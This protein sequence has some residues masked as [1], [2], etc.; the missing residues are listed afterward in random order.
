M[1]DFDLPTPDLRDLLPKLT[2]AQRLELFAGLTR[3]QLHA[4]EYDWRLWARPAQLLPAGDWD[5]WLIL[6]GRGWGKTRTGAEAVR[7]WARTPGTRIALVGR[8][9]A[10]VRDVVVEGQTGVLAVHPPSERPLYEP[11]KRRLTW[12]NGAQATCYSADEPDLLRGPQH[13]KALCD[14]L[15]TW[16]RLEEAWDN[17]TLG[18]RLGDHPQRAIATT[19]RP[20][21]LL[22]K[23]L[24]DPRC[25]VTRGSTYENA[26]N[27]PTSALA[28]FRAKYEGTRLGRQELGAEILDDVPGAL[29]TRAMLDDARVKEAPELV[30]V[31]VAV[32]PAVSSGEDADETGIVVAGASEAGHFYVLA[33]RSCRASP[34][35]WARR[36]VA[37]YEEWRADRIVAETNQGGELCAATVRTVNPNVPFTAVTATRGKRIRAEPIS[38]LYEQGKV[39]H[40]G[41]FAELEDQ[42]CTWS[43]E[44]AG[45]PDR[46]DALVWALTELSGAVPWGGFLEYCRQQAEAMAEKNPALRRQMEAMDGLKDRIFKR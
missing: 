46:M 12:R 6:A 8:T 21:P 37:A 26:A 32:D 2:T 24:T 39:H 4:L 41:G 38:A 36:A 45:S 3:E 14:E 18:L 5:T 20:L 19:P 22:R 29:W 35:A 33:D 1:S 34:D 27:L 23:L 31:V 28:E 7:E 43:P 42:L 30:R 9:A 40:V 13:H 17:L 16:G 44:S 15:A 11:S 10:D 25:V